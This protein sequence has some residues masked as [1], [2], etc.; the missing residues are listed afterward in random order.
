MELTDIAPVE[1]WIQLEKNISR[2]T[3]MN[4]AVFNAE[5][6][7]ITDFVFWANHLCPRI[8]SH[9]KGQK[10]ICAVA[11]QN[12]A[13]RAARSGEAVIDACDAGMIKLVVPVMVG[14]DLLGVAG[15]CGSLETGEAVDP[16]LIHKTI[17]M[18]EDQVE[19]LAADIRVISRLQAETYV[20]FIEEQIQLIV[21][22]FMRGSA[23]TA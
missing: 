17:G 13:A 8:K 7:R 19:N 12:L 2:H 4:A 22:C 20:E 10:F 5:G 11:H 1:D 18:S 23:M 6:M 21:S 3:G 14:G 16:F 15:G 9:E